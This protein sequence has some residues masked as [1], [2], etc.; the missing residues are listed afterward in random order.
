MLMGSCSQEK[1]AEKLGISP[2]TV[3]VYLTNLNTKLGI[4][5]KTELVVFFFNFLCEQDTV[6]LS[7]SQLRLSQDLLGCDT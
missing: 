6:S 2:N 3:R 5:S 1:I 7:G 4:K